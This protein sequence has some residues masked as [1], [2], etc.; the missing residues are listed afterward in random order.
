MYEI[1]DFFSLDV[2]GSEIEV[3]ESFNFAILVRC[4]LIE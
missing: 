3:L 2:E 1:I 4:I